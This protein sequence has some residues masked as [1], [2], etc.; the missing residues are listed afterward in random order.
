MTFYTE[1][2]SNNHKCLYEYLQSAIHAT[3]CFPFTAFVNPHNYPG[4]KYYFEPLVSNKE[5]ETQRW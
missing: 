2:E 1:E 4:G 3:K 5:T